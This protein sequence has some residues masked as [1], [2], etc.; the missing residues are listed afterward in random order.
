VAKKKRKSNEEKLKRELEI[1]KA[2]LR[3]GNA[4]V[5]P[6]SHTAAITAERYDLP[7]ETIKKDLK[8]TVL[9]ATIVLSLFAAM[10]YFKI[11][12]ARVT[13]VLKSN[14]GLNKFI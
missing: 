5:A 1:L 6:T 11:D 2:Q 13:N 8:K 14:F 9:F 3:K 4:P 10:A 12:L 7:I